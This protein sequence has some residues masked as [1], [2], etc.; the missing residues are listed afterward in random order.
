MLKFTRIFLFVLVTVGLSSASIAET[1]TV[2][3]SNDNGVGS[4]RQAIIDANANPSSTTILINI[5]GALGTDRIINVPKALPAFTTLVELRVD[6]AQTGKA[7][8]K[9]PIISGP[10]AAT[11]GLTFN[12]GSNS[13]KVE[14]ITFR[15]FVFSI[16]LNTGGI[17]INNNR[18]ENNQGGIDIRPVASGGNFIIGNTFTTTNTGASAFAGISGGNTFK[19]NGFTGTGINISGGGNIIGGTGNAD[20]N[21]FNNT[22]GTAINIENGSGARILHNTING[23]QGAGITIS[24]VDA[25]VTFNNL[26]NN[27][28]WDITVSGGWVNRIGYN[29]I[30]GNTGIFSGILLSNGLSYSVYGNNVTGGSIE[31]Q[32]LTSSPFY[33][34]LSVTNN[35]ISNDPTGFSAHGALTLTNVTNARVIQ[36]VIHHNGA[37]GIYLATSTN[38]LLVSNIIYENFRTGINV[39]TN[40]Y[41]K[42]SQNFINA[43]HAD[44]NGGKTGIFATA[45]AAPVITSAKRIGTNFVLTGTGTVANDS[46]E[47]FLS[48][49]ATRNAT[50]V[51]NAISYRATVKATGPTWTATISAADLNSFETYFI[52]TATDANNT[53]STFSKAVGVEINGPT[54][55]TINQPAT[56]YAEFIPGASYS[57][58]STLPISNQTTNGNQA[59]F[60]FNQVGAGTVWVGYTDPTTGAWKM[61][62]LAVNVVSGARTTGNDE[63]TAS[64]VNALAYPNPFIS[65]TQVNVEGTESISIQLFDDKGNLVYSEE[66]LAHGTTVEIG[67]NLNPG[68]YTMKTVSGSNVNTSRIVKAQ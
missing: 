26:S 50:L 6:G 30:T 20:P 29:Q 40:L 49:R 46:L 11:T 68:I 67:H 28:G 43:N 44:V 61:Y 12:L 37:N 58:W 64:M 59:I 56:Y 33:G 27:I 47:F 42:L 9:A 31:L 53:T 7:V 45:K 66:G 54:T 21:T 32:D 60:T 51:Q 65:S 38:N 4:L 36:N 13:S 2:T 16:V 52:A 15:D 10:G 3:N 62:S 63:T 19:G 14:F 55:A 57:W 24:G 1:I 25:E 48:D 35:S 23:S 8:L 5:P 18:F 39:G 34:S 22:P 17:N 41:N